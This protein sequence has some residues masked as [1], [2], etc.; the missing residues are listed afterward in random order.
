[1]P[2]N[3]LKN[4]E[5]QS[6][7]KIFKDCAENRKKKSGSTVSRASFNVS[8]F[9]CDI[10]RTWVPQRSDQQSYQSHLTSEILF[11][12]FHGTVKAK[13]FAKKQQQ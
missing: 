12:K 5:T 6:G 9:V 3:V 10:L 8:Q 2:V 1:M 4:Q 7:S 11:K 13:C